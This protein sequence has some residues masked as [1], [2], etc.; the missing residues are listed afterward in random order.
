[1]GFRTGS[2]NILPV[3]ASAGAF[4]RSTESTGAFTRPTEY[5]YRTAP[6]SVPGIGSIVVSTLSVSMHESAPRTE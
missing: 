2:A 5:E 4:A 6:I 1:M 3:T